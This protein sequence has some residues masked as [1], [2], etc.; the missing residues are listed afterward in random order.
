MADLTFSN[1]DTLFPAG[2]LTQ[3]VDDV[4]ISIKALTGE[5]SIQLSTEKVSEF[6][7]K[8]LAA[9][10]EAQTAYNAGSPPNQITSYPSPTLGSPRVLSTGETVSSRTHTVTVVA[11]LQLDEIAANIS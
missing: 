8:F 10:S 6:V 3:T 2:S 5:T 4:T 9:C 1:L 7:S 11:P